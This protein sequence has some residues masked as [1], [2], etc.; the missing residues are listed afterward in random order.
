MQCKTSISYFNYYSQMRFLS[1]HEVF[2][3]FKMCSQFKKEVIM[4]VGLLHKIILTVLAIYLIADYI[5]KVDLK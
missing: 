5:I 1:V 4:K 3:Y 2:V